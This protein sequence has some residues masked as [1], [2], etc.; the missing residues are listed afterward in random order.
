VTFES[1]TSEDSSVPSGIENASVSR[2]TEV[3]GAQVVSRETSSDPVDGPDPREASAREVPEL[4]TPP[5]QLATWFPGAA[6][7]L[8]AYAEILAT[9][10][11]V[12]GL[13]GPREV[14]RLW[15]R[16]LLNCA[17]VEELIPAGSSVGDVGSGA[18]LPGLVLAIVR[19]DLHVSLIEASLRR[20]TFLSEAVEKLGLTNVTVVRARAEEL[21]KTTRLDVVVSRAVAPLP[22]LAAWCAPLLAS[23]GRMLALKGDTAEQELIDAAAVLKKLKM[24]DGRVVRVGAEFVSPPTTVLETTGVQRVNP[25]RRR[26]KPKGGRGR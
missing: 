11:V 18:G 19:P 25:Q 4:P 14:P 3:D 24:R 20:S 23:D 13:I 12:R 17:V 2:E 9:D 21:P 5:A 7:R 8:V 6:E 26:A 10:G 16:H 1:P 22:K 15:E